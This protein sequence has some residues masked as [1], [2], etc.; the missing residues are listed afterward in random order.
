MHRLPIA[1][2]KITHDY[3]FDFISYVM[4]RKKIK[5]YLE[6]VHII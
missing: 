4:I 2:Q 6:L 5:K 1:S 3:I